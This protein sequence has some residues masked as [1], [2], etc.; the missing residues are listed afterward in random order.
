VVAGLRRRRGD[1]AACAEEAGR[2]PDSVELAALV[3]LWV[4]DDQRDAWE[5][6][7]FHPAAAANHLRDAMNRHPDSHGLPPDL[8][9]LVPENFR[10]DYYAG[11]L[12][13]KAE[14]SLEVPDDL[15]DDYTIAGSPE[16]CLEKIAALAEIGIHELATVYLT[17]EIDQLDRVGREIIP[18]LPGRPV[19][20]G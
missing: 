20:T 15:I 11:H 7:R 4:S 2:D 10:Y 12:D 17:G 18:H 16:K 9:K 5:H 13:A 8:V 3:A 14:H 19:P 6:T 1:S